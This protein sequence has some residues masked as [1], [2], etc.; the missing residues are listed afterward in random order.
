MGSINSDFVWKYLLR[1]RH[2]RSLSPF[3]DALSFGHVLLALLTCTQL[4]LLYNDLLS[5]SHHLPAWVQWTPCHSSS[6]LALLLVRLRAHLSSIKMLTLRIDTANN[7][8]LDSFPE[9]VD[10]LEDILPAMTDSPRPLP[11]ARL[12]SDS[13]SS[14]GPS[15]QPS[16]ISV[17]L[18]AH[19]PRNGHRI[20]RS[21]TVGYIAPEFKGKAEQMSAG[22]STTIVYDSNTGL[23]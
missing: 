21:A 1:S 9:Y 14:R 4:T 12:Q 2:F 7:L 22:K 3:A 18:P 17:S 20:L 10:P 11:I 8:P 5:P 23:S 19:D 13:E 15:P 6:V 16:H